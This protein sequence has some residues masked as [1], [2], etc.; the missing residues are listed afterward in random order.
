[1]RARPI[2]WKTIALMLALANGAADPAR[3]AEDTDRVTIGGYGHTSYFRTSAN[4]YR[5]IDTEGSWEDSLVALQ[6]VARLDDRSRVWVQLHN[7]AERSRVDWTFFDFRA[8]DRTTLR[9][10]QIKLPF[11]F[12]NEIID[13]RFLHLSTQTP[14]VYQE[15]AGFAAESFR[16]AS[17]VYSPTLGGSQFDLTGYAGSVTRGPETPET[18]RYKN[19]IGGQIMVRPGDGGLRFAASFYRN[20]LEQ[21]DHNLPATGQGTKTSALLSAEYVDSA[22]D[23]KA[24][25]GTARFL[26]VRSVTA[27]AQVGYTIFGR[28]TPFVRFDSMRIDGNALTDHQRQR[29]WSAGLNYRLT[30]NVALRLEGRA[31]RG[32]ALPY[33]EWLGSAPE[34]TLDPAAAPTQSRWNLLGASVNFIF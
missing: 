31:N 5:G 25:A 6:F 33:A 22:W 32:F 28:W 14:M 16:G 10:G 12:Y 13:A 15:A 8:T 4:S 19:L 2:K 18:T 34:G 21:A 27:Y 26:G 24:E 20:R 11:G 30:D 17:V 1:M 3:A 29:T 23:A 7:T 9:L